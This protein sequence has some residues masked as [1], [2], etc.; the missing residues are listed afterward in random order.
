MTT[1]MISYYQGQRI[2]LLLLVWIRS[3]HAFTL[4]IHHSPLHKSPLH[5]SLEDD[6]DI[7]PY[8]V[9]EDNAQSTSQTKETLKGEGARKLQPV[10]RARRS[11]KVPLLAVIGR[12]NVGK[13]ALVNRIAGTQSG[14]W[15]IWFL[16]QLVFVFWFPPES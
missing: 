8:I 15:Y 9:P 5:I 11:K 7:N 14:T 16:F 2:T 1:S 10:R 4:P 3:L 6:L 13:S 12:P